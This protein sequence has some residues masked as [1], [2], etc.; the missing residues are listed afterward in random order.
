MPRDTPAVIL[1]PSAP[2]QM[3]IGVAESAIFYAAPLNAVTS[4]LRR[5]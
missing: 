2:T 3:R 5:R 4:L 1:E